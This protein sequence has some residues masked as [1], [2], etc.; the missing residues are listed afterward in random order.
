MILKYHVVIYLFRFLYSYIK[1]SVDS[2]LVVQKA[3]EGFMRAA[4]KG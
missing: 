4:S 3:L 1:A 2:Y